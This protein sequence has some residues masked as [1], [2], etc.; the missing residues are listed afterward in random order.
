LCRV[1]AVWL[2][3]DYEHWSAYLADD[4]P[5]ELAFYCR[6]CADTRVRRLEEVVMN[7]RKDARGTWFV[8]VVGAVIG[9]AL[10][11]L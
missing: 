5:P 10:G 8:L 9:L 4:Q 11:I 3:A 1:G 7:A 2:P 6:E